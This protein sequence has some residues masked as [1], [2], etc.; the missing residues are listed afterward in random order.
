MAAKGLPAARVLE[1]VNEGE[2]ERVGNGSPLL[3]VRAALALMN[4]DTLPFRR[5]VFRVKPVGPEAG[6]DLYDIQQRIAHL[7]DQKW[8]P[9]SSSAEHRDVLALMLR[10]IALC[11][12]L[13]APFTL[14]D[15][16][17]W[18]WQLTHRP[19]FGPDTTEGELGDLIAFFSLCRMKS[20][21]VTRAWA[22]TGDRPQPSGTPA[23]QA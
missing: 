12:T 17:T 14:F 13:V 10:A 9:Q 23:P 21:V 1:L 11:N 5:R 3:N 22:T 6:L 16:L 19:P 15:R 4:T 20:N 8:T 2:A 7:K 18:R